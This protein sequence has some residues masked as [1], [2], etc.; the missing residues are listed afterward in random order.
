MKTN[1]VFVCSEC[2]YET[3][4]W[5]GRCSSCGQWNTLTEQITSEKR[6][7]SPSVSIQPSL[8]TDLDEKV[9]EGKK[10]FTVPLQEVDCVMGKALAQ[11]SFVLLGGEPGIGKSTLALQIAKYVPGTLSFLYVTGEESLGQLR[12]RAERLG[13]LE[14]VKGIMLA[15]VDLIA[16]HLR[17]QHYDV[18][19]LDSLHTLYST[20]I[21]GTVGSVSQIKYS[22]DLLRRI[23]KEQQ[24]LLI[25]IAHITKEGDIA[26]PKMLEHMVD[27][28]FYLEG[29]RDHSVR[30][31]RAVKNRYDAVNTLGVLEMT[32]SG[33]V[34]VVDPGSLFW[35]QGTLDIGSC[36]GMIKQG[37][38]IFV[39]EV[40]ALVIPSDFG[41]P[42]R[43][44]LGVD[45]NRLH[46]ILAVLQKHTQ[47]KF[48][49]YDVYIKLKGGLSADD[50]V[51]DGAIA[52]ALLSSYYQKSVPERT[53]VLGEMELSGR[54][55]LRNPEYAKEAKKRGLS[56]LKADSLADITLGN[57]SEK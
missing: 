32:E 4:K 31:L 30:F 10:L 46:T 53:I 29:E 38:R 37:K 35:T 16:D 45:V 28:V 39:T 2:G 42:R 51:L 20:N 54:M 48:N 14:R 49:K 41:Y 19:V 56:L 8:L 44:A 43:T 15:D 23:A 34:D 36:L 13:V 26:G 52:A 24:I 18:V 5:L 25:S 6:S 47:A 1:V 11:S 50:P 22:V 57:S 3:S 9:G 55:L 7:S 40:Q 17:E 21:P 27:A 33:F 12:G